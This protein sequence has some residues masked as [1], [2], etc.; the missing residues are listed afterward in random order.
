VGDAHA[1]Q[2][3]VQTSNGGSSGT[4]ARLATL[5]FAVGF[6]DCSAVVHLTRTSLVGDALCGQE[7]IGFHGEPELAVICEECDRL[8]RELGGEPADWVRV[9]VVETHMLRHAA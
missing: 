2:T 7:P 5:K 6:E 1:V 4:D 9:A 3:P 8:G